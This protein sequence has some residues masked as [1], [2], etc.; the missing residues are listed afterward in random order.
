MSDYNYFL[1]YPH[2]RILPSGK[3]M[4]VYRTIFGNGRL[5][6]AR[7]AH[8]PCYDGSW[9]YPSVADAVEAMN[10]WNPEAEA[11]PPDGWFRE[12]HTGVRRK[13]SDPA[14]E[15]LQE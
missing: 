7:S 11:R 3:A 5:I 13:D 12:V 10:A 2:H 6:I 8:S 4:G 1:E 14:Q 9:C 15:Y